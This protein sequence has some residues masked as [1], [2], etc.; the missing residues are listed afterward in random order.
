M[1]KNVFILNQNWY[2]CFL[3][4]TFDASLPYQNKLTVK[5]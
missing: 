2:L 4:V 1:S 5:I 3:F